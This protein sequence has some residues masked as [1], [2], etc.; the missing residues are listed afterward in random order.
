[1]L[2]DIILEINKRKLDNMIEND[3]SYQKLLVQSRKLDKYVSNKFRLIN[4]I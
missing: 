2:L 3:E 4:P 1:M